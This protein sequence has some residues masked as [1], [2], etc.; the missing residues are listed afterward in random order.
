MKH[1]QFIKNERL[2]RQLSSM[3]KEI[4]DDLFERSGLPIGYLYKNDWKEYVEDTIKSER[5][6]QINFLDFY[7]IKKYLKKS[8]E[9]K[10]YS[11]LWIQQ[12]STSLLCSR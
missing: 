6:S 9:E 7:Q 4:K 5:L 10:D 11:K 8:K 3:K 1:N 2:T 12:R